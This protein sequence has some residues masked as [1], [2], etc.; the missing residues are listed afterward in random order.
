MVSSWVEM[1]DWAS[2]RLAIFLWTMERVCRSCIMSMARS[3][4]PT[5]ISSMISK[6]SISGFTFI[7]SAQLTLDLV[8]QILWICI[9]GTILPDKTFVR[10]VDAFSISL[11]VLYDSNSLP[12]ALQVTCVLDTWV[13]SLHSMSLVCCNW[14]WKFPAESGHYCLYGKLV[15]AFA[16]VRFFV[17]TIATL[18]MAVKGLLPC[19]CICKFHTSGNAAIYDQPITLV[20]WLHMSM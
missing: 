7:S 18:Q 14:I 1:M 4:N 13:D 5:T 6:Q 10:H 15:K 8:V 17:G 20:F 12:L 19:S 9:L 16:S 11:E 2:C 3:M